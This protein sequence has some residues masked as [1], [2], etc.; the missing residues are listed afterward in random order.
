MP[1]PNSA[2]RPASCAQYRADRPGPVPGRRT[3]PIVEFECS[4][5]PIPEDSARGVRSASLWVRS[6]GAQLAELVTRVDAGRLRIHVAPSC[7][8][9]S[10]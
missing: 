3:D 6:D 10:A 2:V 4:A 9:P 1:A 5:G 7:W 8:Q